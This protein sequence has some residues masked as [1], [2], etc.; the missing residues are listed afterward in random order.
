[1]T[2]TS[3]VTIDIVRTVTFSA[4]HRY[5]SPALSREENLK[6]YGSLYRDEGFGHNFLVEA[7]FTGVVDRMTGMIAYLVDL[8]Q[9]LRAVASR[10]DHRFLNELAEFA[11]QAPTLERLALSFYDGVSSLVSG[12]AQLKKIRLYEGD[13]TWVDYAG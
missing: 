1:V 3:D 13:Q 11:G 2:S 10:F 8:E 4:A 6:T 5:A 9:W 7:H 12:G